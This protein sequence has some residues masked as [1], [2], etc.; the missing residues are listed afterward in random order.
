MHKKEDAREANSVPDV[1]NLPVSREKIIY[2][3]TMKK[4]DIK[5]S[6]WTGFKIANSKIVQKYIL[7]CFDIVLPTKWRRY[8]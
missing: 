2:L 4:Q 3:D 1:V 8:L 7:Q 5:R 6:I